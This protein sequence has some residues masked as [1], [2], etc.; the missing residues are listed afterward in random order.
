MQQIPTEESFSAPGSLKIICYVFS[1]I[2][3]FVGINMLTTK[4]MAIEIIFLFPL[5]F[6]IAISMFIYTKLKLIISNA[7]VRFVGGLKQHVFSWSEVTKVDMIRVGKY[8]T[9]IATVY[10]SNRKLDL[11]KGFYLQPKFNRILSLLELAVDPAL[12]TEEYQVIR[13]QIN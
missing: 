1:I 3:L 13:H 6:L 4:D 11:H 8:Q 5:I 2:L 12:F 7:G 9:P 10:Y